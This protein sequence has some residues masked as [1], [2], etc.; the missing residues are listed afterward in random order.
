MDLEA[1]HNLNIRR[2]SRIIGICFLFMFFF[3]VFAEFVVRTS[4][5][6][7]ENPA[8]TFNNIQSNLYLFNTGIFAWM[9]VVF[10]DLLVVVAFYYLLK[11]GDNFMSLFM[12]SLRLLYVAI[13]GSALV[14]LLMAQNVVARTDT[15]AITESNIHQ[16]MELLKLHYYG[17]ALA[18]FFFGI[19]LL[20]LAIAFRKLRRFPKAL[21]WSLFAAGIGYSLNSLVTIFLE[22][23]EVVHS[24]IL[25]IFIFPMTFS[26][27]IVGLWLW[28][29]HEKLNA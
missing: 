25:I 9:V 11:T 20:A 23:L 21:I 3:G 2:S 4:L 12:F 15:S 27:L 6:Q 7:W 10:L 8:I 29:K 24:T 5:I 17:F 16:V 28:V 1:N 26:E 13:K 18:L 14:G 19:H 22:D